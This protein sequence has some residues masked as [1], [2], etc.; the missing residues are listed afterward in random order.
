MKATITIKVDVDYA[1]EN[2]LEELC[3][4]LDTACENVTTPKGTKV[5][6]VRIV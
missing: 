2:K 3:D 4:Y 5:L 1:T 6:A